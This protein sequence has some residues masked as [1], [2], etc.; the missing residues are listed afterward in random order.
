MNKTVFITGASR[1]IGYELSQ[2]FIDKGYYVIGTSRNGKISNLTHNNFEA[3]KLDLS[4]RD[5]ITALKQLLKTKDYNIDILI[6]N[7]G[8]GPDLDTFTP[9]ENTFEDTFKVNVSGTVFLTESIIPYIKNQ[10]KIINI[11]SK[12]G[13]INF[14]ELTDSVAYR[15]SKSA[16]NMYTKIITN[17]LKNTIKVASIHPGWVQ[18]TISKNSSKNGRLSPVESANRLFNFITGEFRSGIFWNVESNEKIEW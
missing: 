6:N 12:M 11:S 9:Q 1:G 3:I 4:K 5:S 7:A 14:C 17:R 2:C 16:L 13:S 10:G 18:T 15:M 8:V